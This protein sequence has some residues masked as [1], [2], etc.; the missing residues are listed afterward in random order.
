MLT[1]PPVTPPS[2]RPEPSALRSRTRGRRVAWLALAVTSAAGLLA[3]CASSNPTAGSTPAA[4][5]ATP[6]A[7]GP[8]GTA[9]ASPAGTGTTATGLDGLALCQPA[10]LRVAV[11]ASQAGVAAG[12]MYY[13]V[14]FTNTAS[15]PCGLYGYPGMSFV[16][17]ADST[18]RQIGAPAQ[19]NPGFGKVAVR[20]AAG[21]E[22]HAWLQVTQAGNYPSA[23]CQPVT[24]HWLRVYAP[25]ETEALYVNQA[26]SACSSA[27]VQLLTVMPVR[28]GQG[29][30]G[31][32]P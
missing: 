6:K 16:T 14:D 29:V 3:G 5:K 1:T 15:S 18:G 20:L 28:P 23:T 31:S 13:P 27:S 32:T 19:Q 10:S 8:G 11:N 12:S 2:H 22:A 25:G 26:F 4:G 9:A 24:A 17:S 21:G 7:H 30:R